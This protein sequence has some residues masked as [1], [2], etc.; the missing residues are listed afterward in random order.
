ME[1]ALA[2][3][4]TDAA[5]KLLNATHKG[6][7]DDFQVSCVEVDFLQQEATTW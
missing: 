4:N 6:L 7:R 1:I 5:G 3:G 2:S